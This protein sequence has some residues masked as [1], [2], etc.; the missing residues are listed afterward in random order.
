MSLDVSQI[1][2]MSLS[3]VEHLIKAAAAGKSLQDRPS[4]PTVDF[5]GST[6]TPELH[7]SFLASGDFE[8]VAD[9][10]KNQLRIGS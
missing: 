8:T 2:Y 3:H 9:L 7:E 10:D 5:D 1:L 6:L 4:V